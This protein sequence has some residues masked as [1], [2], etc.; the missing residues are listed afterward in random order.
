MLQTKIVEKIKAHI[1]YLVAFFPENLAVYE[2]NV[3]KY[4]RTRQATDDNITRRTRF[5][6]WITES[7]DM[8]SEY[9][10]LIAFA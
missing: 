9:V 6:C 10:I 2:D 7:I 5:A 3:K 4:G 1:T 8:H